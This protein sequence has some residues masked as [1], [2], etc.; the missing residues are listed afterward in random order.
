MWANNL[1]L[2][3]KKQS[4]IVR[5][6]TRVYDKFY[7]VDYTGQIFLFTGRVYWLVF[8]AKC[9]ALRATFSFGDS[10]RSKTELSFTDSE[11]VNF[12]LTVIGEKLFSVN[13]CKREEKEKNTE[14]REKR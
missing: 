9:L 1:K 11:I 2:K 14:K 8:I 6:V 13:R 3:W 5:R 4:D 7:A 10:L 12:K